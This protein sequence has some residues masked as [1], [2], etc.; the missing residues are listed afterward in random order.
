MLV[1]F[2]FIEKC[3]YSIWKSFIL[4]RVISSEE[5]S[6]KSPTLS[7]VKEELFLSVRHSHNLPSS[8]VGRKMSEIQASCKT[9]LGTPMRSAEE[10]FNAEI[11]TQ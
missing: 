4:F 2:K 5:G 1:F 6:E 7:I 10:T 8:I 3:L 9:A 11:D